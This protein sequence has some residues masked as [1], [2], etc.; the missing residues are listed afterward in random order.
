M[1]IPT[2][3]PA[4]YYLRCRKAVGHNSD[5][6]GIKTSHNPRIVIARPPKAAVAI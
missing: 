5:F 4:R 6:V 2:L 1:V 3:E